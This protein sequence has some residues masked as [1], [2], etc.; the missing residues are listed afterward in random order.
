MD[1]WISI[2]LEARQRRETAVVITVAS[3]GGSVPREA[4]TRMIVTASGAHGSIGGG[5]L[6]FKAIDI[7]RGML[8]TEF[9]VDNPGTIRQADGPRALHRFPLGATLGQCCGGVVNLLFE[10]VPADADWVEP[11]ASRV[12]S[13]KDCIIVTPV[14]GDPRAGK[15]IVDVVGGA[16]VVAAGTMGSGKLDDDA[17]AIAQSMLSGSQ[18]TML[19]T[20]SA[21]ASAPAQTVFFDRLRATDFHIVLFGAGHVGRALVKVMAGIACGITW[22][23]SRDDAFPLEFPANVAPVCTDAP[24]SEVDAARPGSYF[25]VMTHSHALDQTLAERI[26][27]R[28]DFA[29]FGLIGSQSKRRQFVRRLLDRGISPAQLARMTCPIGA[30]GIAGKEPATIAIAIAAEILQRRSELQRATRVPS[31]AKSAT[32]S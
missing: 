11:A 2:L 28:A 26:L 9:A 27:L 19:K 6:E 1:N 13:A 4:G 15:L 20:L 21:S 16:C 12:A 24:E 31:L 14:A 3:T 32:A 17:R 7:A 18:S 5:H 22:V 23:D 10:P 8:S 25:L 30:A 29:H